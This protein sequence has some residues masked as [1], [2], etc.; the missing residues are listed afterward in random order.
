M[1]EEKKIERKVNDT[2][3]SLAELGDIDAHPFLHAHLQTRISEYEETKAS[4]SFLRFHMRDLR[5]AVL[6]LLLS[7]NIIAGLFTIHSWAEDRESS[8]TAFAE[9]YIL[10]R[11]IRDIGFKL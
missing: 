3:G 9:A 4:P 7:F 2:L 11:D 10:N 6:L 8:Q 5:P 1:D